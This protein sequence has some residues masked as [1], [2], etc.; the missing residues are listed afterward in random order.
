M[1]FVGTDTATTGPSQVTSAEAANAVLPEPVGPIN[2]TDPR[3]PCRRALAASAG[4]E[5]GPRWPAAVREAA[6]GP[7]ASVPSADADQGWRAGRLRS[8]VLRGLRCVAQTVDD[9]WGRRC[10]ATSTPTRRRPQ[11]RLRRRRRWR[12]SR[13]AGP[14]GCVAPSSHASAGAWPHASRTVTGS[15]SPMP[16]LTWPPVPPM[17]IASR[18]PS[19]TVTPAAITANTAAIERDL[20][21]GAWLPYFVA[22]GHLTHVR[23]SLDDRHV[24]QGNLYPTHA[25]TSTLEPSTVT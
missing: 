11:Q 6:F 8:E 19:H 5:R 10:A 7:A 9:R 14:G 24:R 1:G 15:Q 3:L 17:T 18:A 20:E 2:A 13:S 23:Q 25:A 22:G 4:G 16:P 21:P 12:S